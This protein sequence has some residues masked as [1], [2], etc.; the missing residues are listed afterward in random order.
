M[1][2]VLKEPGTLPLPR[3]PP[4]AARALVRSK[5]D[6]CGAAAPSLGASSHLALSPRPPPRGQLCPPGHCGRNSQRWRPF[7]CAHW[8]C[9]AV[10]LAEAPARSPR[11]P[12]IGGS[13]GV[14][15]RRDRKDR[16][17]VLVRMVPPGRGA[18]R[19]GRKGRNGV[20]RPRGRARC[21]AGREGSHTDLALGAR[22][23]PP[24][25]AC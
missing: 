10:C 4:A 18:A 9:R 23:P 8:S 13:A 2:R 3:P 12:R 20:L 6:S 21:T 5:P 19:G 15:L 24:A 17:P 16:V 7:S 11:G 14:S 25:Y 22:A 1:S